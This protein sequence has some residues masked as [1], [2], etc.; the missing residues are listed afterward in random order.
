MLY[1]SEILGASVYRNDKNIGNVEN[2][3]LHPEE[4]IIAGFLLERRNRDI[5]YRYFPYSQIETMKRD[6]IDLKGSMELK[7]LTK[8]DGKQYMFCEDFLKKTIQDDKG[9]ILPMDLYGI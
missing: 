8:A 3:M 5:R 6:R 4:K 2:L 7:T 9:V 1:W